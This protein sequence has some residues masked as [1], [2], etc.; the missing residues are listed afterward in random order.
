MPRKT[1]SKNLNPKIAKKTVSFRMLP[2]HRDA[3]EKKYGSLQR[4]AETHLVKEFGDPK[5]FQFKEVP[6]VK[7]KFASKDD[8]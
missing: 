4:W 5:R 2:F 1:G 8:F 6:V 7:E 3:L